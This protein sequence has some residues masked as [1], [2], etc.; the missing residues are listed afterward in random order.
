MPS[1]KI[2]PR[3]AIHDSFVGVVLKI[4]EHYLLA[5]A[6]LDGYET[7]HEG[8]FTIRYGVVYLG[9]PHYSIVPDLLALD[10]GELLTGEEAWDFLIN[11]SNLYPRADVFGYRNDGTDEQVFVK[12]LDL[13][14]HFDVLVYADDEATTPL[15]KVS[16]LVAENTDSFPDRL[17]DYLETFP[18]IKEW[19]KAQA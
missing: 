16:A 15:A 5:P 2:P 8:K 1:P 9:K 14:W 19:Q 12:Q 4:D 13:M 10:Y 3:K 18:S 17:L 11:K 6:P 7:L